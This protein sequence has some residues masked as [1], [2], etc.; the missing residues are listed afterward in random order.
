M[1]ATNLRARFAFVYNH[2]ALFAS[3]SGRVDANLFF[4]SKYAFFN[5]TESVSLI[6]G[7]RF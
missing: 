6:V 2:K 5:S 3:L 1:L 4:N 7:A